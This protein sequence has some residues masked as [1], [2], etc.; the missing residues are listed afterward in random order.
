MTSETRCMQGLKTQN[1]IQ[2]KLGIG[3]A[4]E[5]TASAKYQIFQSKIDIFIYPCN[6]FYYIWK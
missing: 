4:L 3:K 1:S 2:L 5:N 6:K